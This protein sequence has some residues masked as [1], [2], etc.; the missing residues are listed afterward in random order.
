MAEQINVISDYLK[1]VIPD[2]IPVEKY[3]WYYKKLRGIK[4][5]MEGEPW[6]EIEKWDEHVKFARQDEPFKQYYKLRM[7]ADRREG[8]AR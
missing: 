5:L 6:D 4:Q 8:F 1:T 3:E 2:K 7:E